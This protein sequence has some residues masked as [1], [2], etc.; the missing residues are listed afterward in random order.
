MSESDAP[1]GGYLFP[2]GRARPA[3]SRTPTGPGAS[4]A[5]APDAREPAELRHSGVAGDDDALL[6]DALP[7]PGGPTADWWLRV[8]TR[9]LL[10]EFLRAVPRTEPQA[11]L[12]LAHPDGTTHLL[13]RGEL[14]AAIDALRPRQRQIVR[15]AIEERWPRQRVCAY[16]NNISEKT[17]ERDQVEALDLLAGL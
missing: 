4:N 9:Q 14:S 12:A 7:P 1:H 17:L 13:T 5:R 2:A 10:R 3:D 15:L 8:Q 6:G 11:T 16:L